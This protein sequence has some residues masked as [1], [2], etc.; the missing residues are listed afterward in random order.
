MSDG[1]GL[2]LAFPAHAFPALALALVTGLWGCAA[3]PAEDES[4]ETSEAALGEAG[5]LT[6]HADFREEASGVLQKGKKLR[7]AYDEARLTSCRG[8]QFGNPAWAI[9]GFYR[10]GEGPIRTFPVA[11]LSPSGPTEPTL[12]LDASGDLQI[13]F[14]N[15][16]RWGCSAYDS[17]LGRNYR[18][19]VLP[20]AHEPG[21]MG[22][23]RSVISRM[24]CAGGKLCEG[25]LRAVSSTPIPYDTWAR[26]RA[27]I[28]QL[29][30]EVW[31]QGTTDFDNPELWRQL[32]VQ[33][34]YRAGG[35]GDFRT[36]YV[37]LERRVGNNARYAVDLRSLDPIPGIVGIAAADCP[38]LTREPGSP[39]V[40][41]TVEV[42]FTVNGAELRPAGGG[43]FL[44]RYENY[45]DAFAACP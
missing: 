44:V 21:W 29:T 38:P 10:I 35:A 14:Q 4:L 25:D 20:A 33:V 28:R 9:T 43:A 24:T 39:Y 5:T 19:T 42:F 8:E 13:W 32:D 34:H 2:R 12:T 45:A 16:S 11:G 18:F 40:S 30:F 26:Q 41:S 17:N 6:F 31:K 3:S 37:D 23:V 36:A 7:V 22:N 15:T 1:F 27:A